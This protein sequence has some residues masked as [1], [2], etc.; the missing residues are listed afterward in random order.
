MTRKNFIFTIVFILFISSILIITPFTGKVSADTFQNNLSIQR[1][2]G[3][4]RYET[5]SLLCKLGWN[6]T[7]DNVVLTTGEDF[8]DS[9]CA[10]PLAS[11]LNAPLLLTYKDSLNAFTK[12]EII[13]LKPKNIYIIGGK[14]VVSQ[15]IENQLKSMNLNIIRIGGSDRYETSIMIAKFLG[16]ANRIF[17]TTGENFPDSL[18][19]ASIASKEKNPIILSS[20]DDIR[21]EFKDYLNSNNI[22]QSY[23]IGGQALI[24]DKVR[25][26]L[27]NSTRIYGNNRYETN[28]DIINTFS[29]ELDITNVFMTTGENFPDALS[30]SSFAGSKAAPII[31][32]NPNEKEV[33]RDL[34][35][36]INSFTK[37]VFVLGGES[38]VPSSNIDIIPEGANAKNAVN[39]PTY[40]GSN[41]AC[42]PKVLYFPNKWNGWKYWMVMTPYP[43]GNDYWENPSIVVSNSGIQWNKPNG[44]VNPITPLPE[45]SGQHN[46]D[47][48]LVYNEVKNELELW[49]R[50]TLFDKEDRIYKMTSPDGI[51]WSNPKLMISFYNE[52][53]CLSPTIIF[54]NNKYRMWYIN[55]NFNCVYVESS[56]GTQWSN[57]VNVNLNLTDSYVPWHID[58][59]HT[60]LG[61]EA[62]FCGAK[63]IDINLNNRVLFWNISNDGIHFSNSKVVL[64]P[65]N[66]DTAWDNKQIYR[67][68]FVKVNGVYK[69]FYS[70][71][72]KNINWHI[73]LSQGYSLDDLHGYIGYIR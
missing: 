11:K 7:S 53:K 39:I 14:G 28:V 63:K 47:P 22:T 31:L 5:S 8:P 26:Q 64:K 60:D 2:A 65:S 34:F 73:G 42:H 18:S 24:S 62:I 29:D 33:T 35:K 21:Q 17:V 38:V 36:S 51:H 55:Q 52:N 58:V 27:P 30:C 54:E 37:N 72:D 48:H 9:L 44:L 20:K 4:D 10:A 71:M 67:S 6:Q 66:N 43:S 56:D 23:V 59:V 46:S 49:Y 69:L 16:K 70:A 19:V 32:V 12:N 3:S 13:R 50:F 45:K 57:P 25:K 15:A 68:T 1:L 61:Y 41:Q 40:E